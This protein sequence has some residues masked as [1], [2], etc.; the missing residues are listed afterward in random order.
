MTKQR[1]QLSIF[2]DEASSIQDDRLLD[3]HDKIIR[4]QKIKRNKRHNS[5]KI[6]RNNYQRHIGELSRTN[7]LNPINQLDMYR[8]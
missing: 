7:I 8:S 6:V 5:K 4:N 2:I 3:F 1:P